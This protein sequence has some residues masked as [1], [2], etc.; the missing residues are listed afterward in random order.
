MARAGYVF[1]QSEDPLDCCD[2]SG[3]IEPSWKS[4]CG[5]QLKWDVK[6]RLTILNSDVPTSTASSL[7]DMDVKV[8][9]ITVSSLTIKPRRRLLIM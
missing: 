2:V 1:F 4:E 5:F 9:P 7:R 6:N 8:V 3:F